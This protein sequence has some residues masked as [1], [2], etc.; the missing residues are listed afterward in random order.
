MS[1]FYF[2]LLFP[3]VL[4]TLG[5]YIFTRNNSRWNKVTTKE[6]GVSLLGNLL[7]GGAGLLIIHAYI[8]GQVLD[9]YTLNGKVLSKYQESTS[10][11][12][13]Y[14]VC[15]S[16]GKTT[17]CTTYY[18]HYEDY[19]WV[20]KTSVGKIYIERVDRQGTET[21][22]RFKQVVIG[23][24]ASKEFTYSNYL[25]ADKNSLFLQ[26]A[27]GTTTLQQP[28][29][30]DY[31][32]VNHVVGKTDEQLSTYLRNHL[33]GKSY[34]VKLVFVKD[35][36]VEHFYS[37]MKS[38]VGG[39]INDVIIVVS[40]GSDGKVLWVKANTYAK[41]IN[42]QMM[43]KTLEGEVGLGETYSVES[44][45]KQLTVVDSQF[46]LQNSE[47]FEEKISMVELPISLIIVLTIL[48]LIVSIFI[49]VKMKQE[50]F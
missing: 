1:I 16:N 4:V 27:E 40:E 15:T 39:K 25:L 46:K 24:P 34:N 44:L 10:C 18:E 23:E 43:L 33:I 19:D 32:R 21:P 38:W 9:T 41:G 36:P 14:Q 47:D 42:N 7:V 37:I 2:I 13:S 31:Y 22:K 17:T 35:Q 49:H 48:N 30:Y 12:H 29:V 45:K 6:L 20:V 3:A 8:N 11:E 28:R 26:N 5:G 50:D